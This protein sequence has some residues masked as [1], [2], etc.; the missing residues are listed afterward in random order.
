MPSEKR[1]IGDLGENLCVKHLVK[2]G[3]KILD[4]NYQKKWGEIDI[5]AK[6]SGIIHFIE[7]KT[8]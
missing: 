7:V 3:F 4:R 1:K 8:K 2:H 6:K 5:V